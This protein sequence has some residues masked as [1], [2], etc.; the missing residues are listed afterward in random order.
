MTRTWQLAQANVARQRAP[1]SSP[2]MGE[3]VVALDPVNRIAEGS[4]GFVWRL[5]SDE[6][7][8]ATVVQEGSSAMVVNLSVWESYEA[9]HAFVYRSPHGAYLRRRARWFT[10]T[11]PPSTVLWWVEAGER[12][13]V[14]EALRRLRHLRAYG[15]SAQAFTLRRRF[16][17]D[18]RPAGRRLSR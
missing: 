9:L 3:F 2:E 7:H 13:T 10:P 17:P 5:R 8:G 4:P 1:L 15:P 12:P 18:G 16:G 11:P 14:E 6:R